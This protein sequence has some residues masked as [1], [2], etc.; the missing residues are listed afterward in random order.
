MAQ[1][2]QSEFDRIFGKTQKGSDAKPP[3][4]TAT[5]GATQ[6]LPSDSD[7]LGIRTDSDRFIFKNI[8]ESLPEPGSTGEALLPVQQ[9]QRPENAIQDA[10]TIALN[11]NVFANIADVKDKPLISST[12]SELTAKKSG[13]HHGAA[14]DGPTFVIALPKDLGKH[15]DSSKNGTAAPA[16]ASST[17]D[18]FTR[19][20][21]PKNIPDGPNPN[22]EFTR[23]LHMEDS[24]TIPKPNFPQPLDDSPP[25]STI[26]TTSDPTL[27]AASPEPGVATKPGPSDFTKVIKGSELRTLREKLAA[28][29]ANQSLANPPFWQPPLTPGGE[30]HPWRS[31]PSA[32]GPQYVPAPG[33]QRDGADQ[34]AAMPSTQQQPSKLSQ[35]MPVI[36]VLNLLV[37][38]A[39]LLIVFFAIKK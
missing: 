1:D 5:P 4:G 34:S 23:V 35:Y 22:T 19:I 18:E 29:P 12:W 10:L 26:A 37:L 25:P 3:E 16:N 20:L 2:S 13:E 31:E 39:V 32:M 15:L 27:P 30:T 24:V 33:T 9:Q 38:M 7:V 14:A 11:V 36:I 28:A 21:N 8:P 17:V 6:R